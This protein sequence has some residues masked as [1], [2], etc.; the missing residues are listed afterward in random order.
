MVSAWPKL[1]SLVLRDCIVRCEPSGPS[2][3]LG[4]ATNLRH[5]EFGEVW[6][7][8][9]EQPLAHKLPP[10]VS[11]LIVRDS[12]VYEEPAITDELRAGLSPFPT[13]VRHLA[14]LENRVKCYGG[15]QVA[16]GVFDSLIATATEITKLEISP[17]AVSN[18]SSSLGPLVNLAQL[19]VIQGRTQPDSIVAHNEVIDFVKKASGIREVT[20]SA[21]MVAKW[22]DEG[23]RKVKEAAEGRSVR[24]MVK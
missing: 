10:S 2:S 19:S 12:N 24:F 18:L 4:G 3:L 15:E 17:C 21:S 16:R 13:G 11:T 8:N 6:P 1:E 9:T 20:V 14:L 23:L 22:S 5:L 7:V